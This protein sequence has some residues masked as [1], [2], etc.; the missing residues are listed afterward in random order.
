MGPDDETYA[1]TNHQNPA[2]G[3]CQELERH[4]YEATFNNF[5]ARMDW[6][7]DGT[8]NRNPVVTING[9]EGMEITTLQPRQGSS[10]TLD[11]SE[12]YDPDCDDLTFSWWIISGPGT[13]TQ[14]VKISNSNSSRASVEVPEDSAGKTFQVICE[15]TDD[16]MHNLTSYRRII[17]QPGL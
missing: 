9:N 11:A 12:S 14:D 8:G 3:I 10:V 16:G 4:F 1:Y 13:Y 17:F 6:A 5:A 2:N 15:V 7:K